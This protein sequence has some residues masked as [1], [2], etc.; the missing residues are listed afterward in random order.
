MHRLK[1]AATLAAILVAAACTADSMSP[2]GP[3]GPRETISDAAHAGAVPGFYFLPPMVPNPS[4]SGTFDGGLQP[5]VEICELS[6]SVC[7]TTIAQYTTTSGTGGQTVQVG[8]SSY[9]VSWHTSQFNL[10]IVVE[11]P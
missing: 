5:R 3:T 11:P 2:T 7:S 1:R 4:Y 9:Q 8:T 6:G 10:D